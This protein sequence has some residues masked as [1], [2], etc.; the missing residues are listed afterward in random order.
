MSQGEEVCHKAK[1]YVTSAFSVACST[2]RR[3][4]SQLLAAMPAAQGKEVRHSLF[5]GC[6]QPQAKVVSHV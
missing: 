5:Q 1:K 2:R 6:L 3:S 4:M